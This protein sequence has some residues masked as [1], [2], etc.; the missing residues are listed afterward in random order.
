MP[1]YNAEVIFLVAAADCACYR[2]RGVCTAC[3][4][5]PVSLTDALVCQGHFAES[6]IL[7]Y[8]HPGI[9]QN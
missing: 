4:D 5:K 6:I 2:H 8:I 1:I 9:V 7:V 3:K